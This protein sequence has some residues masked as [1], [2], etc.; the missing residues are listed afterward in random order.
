MAR[1]WRARRD[2]ANQ[3]PARR[4]L[5][6]CPARATTPARAGHSLESKEMADG[7]GPGWARYA[8]ERLASTGF[9][10]GGARSAVI[11][12]LDA[13]EC[14]RTAIEIEDALREGGRRV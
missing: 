3:S 11:D 7:Q 4:T 13:Q 8:H 14:A 9:R 6:P 1:S 5:R 2:H 12:F 10:R